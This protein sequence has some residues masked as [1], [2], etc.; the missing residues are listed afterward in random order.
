MHNV[1]N[2]L[3]KS[4]FR[5]ITKKLWRIFVKVMKFLI[6]GISNI[7]QSLKQKK[8]VNLGMRDNTLE[9]RIHLPFGV[10]KSLSKVS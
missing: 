7:D 5:L 4:L 8:W 6:L 2:Q 9:T 10:L 3:N 1:T